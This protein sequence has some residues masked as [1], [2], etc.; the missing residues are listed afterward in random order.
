MNLLSLKSAPSLPPPFP[1]DP[2]PFALDQ[3]IRE[4]VHIIKDRDLIALSGSEA[5]RQAFEELESLIAGWG[6]EGG[7]V[8]MGQMAV[9]LSYRKLAL[10]MDG[11]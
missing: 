6:R 10:A 5:L 2:F 8:L 11:L 1:I 9:A 4:Q 7:D 3:A